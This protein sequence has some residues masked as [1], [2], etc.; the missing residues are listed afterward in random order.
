MKKLSLQMDELRVESFST[1][2]GESQKGTVQGNSASVGCTDYY[3]CWADTCGASCYNTCG[4]SHHRTCGS[5][6]PCGG[7]SID[8]CQSDWC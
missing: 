2:K 5:V 4:E 3:S 8:A 7:D 6:T 1:G